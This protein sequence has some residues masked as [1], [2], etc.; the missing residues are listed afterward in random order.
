MRMSFSRLAAIGA[1]LVAGVTLASCYSSSA[2][3][4]STGFNPQPVGFAG[5]NIGVLQGSPNLNLGLT[6]A[7][8]YLDGKLAAPGL[9]YGAGTPFFLSIPAGSHDFR[10]VQ[11]GSL[12]PVFA[13]QVFKTTAGTK[14]VVIAQGDAAV[15]STD[16]GFYVI[17]HY[18]TSNGAAAFSFFNA[19]PRAI[20]VANPTGA[21]DV[22]YN[23]LN[24]NATLWASNVIVGGHTSPAASWHNNVLAVLSPDYCFSAYAHGTTTPA[25]A[26]VPPGAD[27]F[28]NTGCSP[29]LSILS[30]PA[31]F[32]FGIIDF[33]VAPGIEMGFFIDQ[34]G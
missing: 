3:I 15:H 20:T 6:V 10:F 7:D 1:A 32:D 8:F 16:V 4:P 2:P 29:G 26:S 17:P 27:A 31:N 33:G 13:E 24:C 5:N 30:G 19:S 18:N 21:V 9:F 34:N 12:A 23:C 22:Y 25:L 11:S 28:A 14:Y